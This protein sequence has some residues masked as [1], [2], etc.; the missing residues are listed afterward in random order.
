MAVKIGRWDCPSCGQRGVL[1]PE[2]RCPNCGASRP[3]DVRFYLPSDAEELRDEASIRAARAGADWICGHCHGQNKA[4][5]D[6]CQSCGNPRDEESEDV[7]LQERRY[8]QQEIPVSP[9]TRKR[10]LHPEEIERNKPRKKRS[11]F[12]PILLLIA[13][14]VGGGA[15]P[16]TVEVQVDGFRWERSIQMLHKEAVAHEDWSTPAGAFEVSSFQDI[17]HYNKVFRGYETRTRT[18]RVQTGSRRVACGTIDKG[19]GYFE[20]QY[21]NEPVYESRQ[22]EYQEEIYDQ[23]PVYA[24]KYR[25][26]LWEWVARKDYLLTSSGQDHE[27][28]WPDPSRYNGMADVK[29]GER[30]ARYRVILTRPNGEQMEEELPETSWSSL[31]E[32]SVLSGKAAWLW[33]WWYGLE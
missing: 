17:H 3:R 4:S 20:T 5:Q 28:Q 22:V 18:E 25:Y 9:E 19:N 1:G 7:A 29:E 2:T 24:T 6:T 13:A 30:A 11:F 10:T 33:G 26:K 14:V 32:S 8:S 16:R 15:I 21:C 27:P 23:V 31:S 12:L